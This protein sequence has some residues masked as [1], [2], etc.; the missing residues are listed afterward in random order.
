MSEYRT[1]TVDQYIKAQKKWS[2]ALVFIRQVLQ[3][4]VLEETIKW[5]RPVYTL[6]GKNVLG[7]AGFKNH[8]SIWFFQ[9]VFLKDKAGLLINA[10]EG[11]TKAMR[12]MR[13]ASFDEMNLNIIRTYIDEAIENHKMEKLVKKVEH[14][15]EKVV[16]NLLKTALQSDQVLQIAFDLLTPGR[17]RE[18]HEYIV[19]AK[20]DKTKRR[21]ID[22]I[23]PMILSGIGLN[24]QYRSK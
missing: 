4:T 16:S 6:N 17:R 11:K 8:F 18:Y 22:K 10:Q 21:R 19:T 20:Q 3:D 24:D 14:P 9:G 5:G 12:Q 23:L 7:Y 2:K 13:F 15:R 1:P